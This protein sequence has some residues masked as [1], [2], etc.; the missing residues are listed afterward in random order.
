MSGKMFVA[1]MA[2]VLLSGFLFSAC[3]NS[4]ASQGRFGKMDTNGDGKV[5]LEE[6]QIANPGMNENAFMLIDLNND[7]AIDSNE[8][9]SFMDSHGRN[10]MLPRQERGA[11]MNNIPGDPLIPPMDSNDLPLMQ[12][13]N[14]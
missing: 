9:A 6:F 4:A 14:E 3:A 1:G 5:V 8:W 13:S 12:P 11:P 10:G 7:G 2:G